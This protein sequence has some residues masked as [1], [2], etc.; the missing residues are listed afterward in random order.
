MKQ[1]I[2]KLFAICLLLFLLID[3]VLY[4][5]FDFECINALFKLVDDR[6]VISV[7]LRWVI[8]VVAV[9]LLVKRDAIFDYIFESSDQRKSK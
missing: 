3:S 2:L 6:S 8:I 1:K 4:I 7:I 5:F 9:V